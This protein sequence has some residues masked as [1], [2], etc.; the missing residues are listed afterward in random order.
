MIGSSARREHFIKK[1]Q[2]LSDCGWEP[3]TCRLQ[4]S[5]APV[6]ALRDLAVIYSMR[7]LPSAL[8]GLFLAAIAGVF[9]GGLSAAPSILSQPSSVVVQ[10]GSP[11]NMR[12]SFSSSIGSITIQW[13]V[14][15]VPI[16]SGIQTN[17]PNNTGFE[18]GPVQFSDAGV[19]SFRMADSN[20]YTDSAPIQVTVVSASPPPLADPSSLSLVSNGSMPTLQAGSTARD[21][22]LPITYAWY[23]EGVVIP[24]Q[25][26]ALLSYPLAMGNFAAEL[27]NSAGIS[28]QPDI[29]VWANYSWGTATWIDSARVGNIVY[30]LAT[31]PG[32]VLRYDLV[33]EAWLPAVVLNGPQEPTAFQPTA[34]GVFIA[35]GASLVR[36][37]LDLTSEVAVAT[38]GGSITSLI[39]FGNLVYF[40]DSATNRV[41]AYHQID[42]SSPLAPQL[43]G[44]QAALAQRP[45]VAQSLGK[46]FFRSGSDLMQCSVAGDGTFS[47]SS[48]W[49]YAS[50]FTLGSRQYLSNDEQLVFDSGGGVYSTGDLS[51]RRSLG[52]RFQDLAFLGDGAAVVARGNILSLHDPTAMSEVGQYVLPSVAFNLQVWNEAVYAFG[53]APTASD[54]PT[55]TKVPRSSFAPTAVATAK[56]T[57]EKPFS[58]DDVSIDAQ[59]VVNLVSRSTQGVVRWSTQTR[60]FLPTIQLRGRPSAVAYAP[61]GDAL[62]LG[63]ADFSVTRIRFSDD[64][65]ERPFVNAAG[66]VRATMALDDHLLVDVYSG[67][68]SA[69]ARTIVGSDRTTVYFHPF[70]P[71]RALLWNS[72]NRRLYLP[73]VNSVDG[74]GYVNVPSDYQITDFPTPV[75]GL[76]A[77]MRANSAGTR[78]VSGSGKVV[79][80]D[81]ATVG[82]I[83]NPVADAVWQADGL[84]TIRQV[85]SGTEVQLWQLSGYAQVASL[86]VPGQP[87]RI[88]TVSSTRVVVVTLIDGYIAFHIVDAGASLA[89]SWVNNRQG[90]TITS[91]PAPASFVVSGSRT[92]G[93]GATGGLLTYQWRRNGTAIPGA[94][95]NS[96]R[97]TGLSASDSG[98]SFDVVVSNAY[99]SATSTAATINLSSGKL[100]QTLSFSSIGTRTRYE[101]PFALSASATSQLTPTYSVIS[102]PASIGGN[103][104]TITG[105]GTVVVRASQ[106]GNLFYEAAPSVDQTFVV[107]KSL[108]T[109]TLSNLSQAAD[110]NPHGV[111]VTT[112]PSGLATVVTYDGS[113]T[114]PSG[115]G[116]Y[117][118]IARVNDS[119]YQGGATGLLTL[120]PAGDFAPK[121]TVQPADVAALIGQR[122]VF[123]AS[124]TGS[125]TPTYQWRRDGANVPG[126]IGPTYLLSS[127]SSGDASATFDVVVTNRAGTVTSRTAKLKLVSTPVGGQ[128]YQSVAG[129]GPTLQTVSHGTAYMDAMARQADGKIL[130][131][132]AI[133]YVNGLATGPGYGLVRLNGD[134]TTDGSFSGPSGVSMAQRLI[135]APGGRVYVNGSVGSVSGQGVSAIRLNGDG[136]RDDRF[137]PW[138]ESALTAAADVDGNLYVSNG[139]VVRRLDSTGTVD[140]SFL[141]ASYVG[142]LTIAPLADGSVLIGVASGSSSVEVR[143][144]LH[145]GIEDSTFL[146]IV[147]SS[148]SFGLDPLPDGSCLA[149]S[150]EGVGPNLL[151]SS[152]IRFR[153]DGAKLSTFASPSY[154]STGAIPLEILLEIA[155]VIYDCERAAGASTP[156]GANF[157]IVKLGFP[158]PFKYLGDVR[159]DGEVILVDQSAGARLSKYRLVA[160]YVAPPSTLAI[161]IQPASIIVAAGQTATFSVTA[162]GGSPLSYQWRRNGANLVGQTASSLSVPN[163]TS[164]DSGATFDVLITDGITSIASATAVLTVTSAVPPPSSADNR[165]FFGTLGSGGRFALYVRSS[166]EATLVGY[167]PNGRGSFV[168][169]FTVGPDGSFSTSLPAVAGGGVTGLSVGGGPAR[170]NATSLQLSGSISGGSLSGTISSTGEAMIGA[171][172]PASGTTA[173]LAGLYEAPVI[174]T[175]NGTLYFVVGSSGAVMGASTDSGNTTAA[176]GTIGADGAFTLGLGGATV[177][178]SINAGS[179][180]VSGQMTA[181]GSAPGSFGGVSATTTHT[182]RLVNISTRGLVGD[183]DK[184]MIAGF[185]IS[186]S[187]SKSVLVRASGPTLT[188]YGL[189][190]A[191]DDPVLKIYRGQ[192]V[193]LSNDNWSTSADA[194]LIASTAA[195]VGGFAQQSGSKDAALIT[196]LTPGVY[197]AQVTRADGSSTGVA[198]V[199]VYDASDVPGAEAQ[200]VINIST[201][202]EVG[203]GEK[204]MIAGFV[205]SGNAPKRVLIRAVGPTLGGYGVTGTLADPLLKLYQGETVIASNDDW[206]TIGSAASDAAA[207]VGAFPLNAGSKDAALLLTLAPGVYSAQVSGVGG[208]TGV[209]LI[210]VYEVP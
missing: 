172:E 151:L 148:N 166:G 32:R 128:A 14:D 95:S 1:G 122:V 37:N 138:T 90:P 208:T 195:R 202:G 68:S 150:A 80:A 85:T 177:Q 33:Q 17:A 92:L 88:L 65:V 28:S 27:S 152:V 47:T 94:T 146:P 189:S 82:Q 106:P 59:G 45:A 153:S 73:G 171:A 15:G 67:A 110:G 9:A 121:I 158:V 179:G 21:S 194:S 183:G 107:T 25:T 101:A 57:D 161:S 126:A 3:W 71:S 125:P 133:G 140:M 50:Q 43:G 76:V 10:V 143:R 174:N 16:P 103:T 124:A 69:W 98:A 96:L 77:P 139:N 188:G 169:K 18:T 185:V 203:T 86:T 7:T 180:A 196:S 38:S 182:D 145:D 204:I 127:A 156:A 176:Q 135:P 24:G 154:S 19:Y 168:V 178:G 66:A 175:A 75:G 29:N 34:N 157:Q 123:T 56:A 5:L 163:T 79:D 35:Y 26:T 207:Q 116:T 22:T 64:P 52:V 198:L 159:A 44:S 61:T 84:Y 105:T 192:D 23:K 30:F 130:L 165:V 31:G 55:V 120:A 41:R 108:A 186:G 91:Q 209:A 131:G 62:F 51:Y 136:T 60:A 78:L 72:A 36:R 20:G 187:Q 160:D 144:L 181:T 112:N 12:V 87:L 190:G 210:E 162:T 11:L 100:P 53:A 113:T 74:I 197:S 48:Y 201:R 119:G 89:G 141:T 13:Y 46:L 115:P 147:M 109:V 173:A 132:G 142:L 39:S 2:E 155:G 170:G 63:Y 114:V 199:E 149:F 6:V 54:N 111:T 102:G 93:V 164:S 99:G 83:A 129:F 205:V 58:V 104:L 200:K 97:L 49:G 184:A 206:G 70:P 167:L 81:L 117:A 42:L 8:R 191:M 137:R 134:G 193:I 118:V 40:Y 4:S